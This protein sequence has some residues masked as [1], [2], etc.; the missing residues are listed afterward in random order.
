MKSGGENL[1]PNILASFTQ[2]VTEKKNTSELE[3][4]KRKC[5]GINHAIISAVRPRSF[6]SPPQIGL[7]FTLHRSP[8]VNE[9]T[10]I[11]HVFD[12]ADVNVRTLDGLNTFHAMG[13]YN[14][15]HQLLVLKPK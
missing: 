6:L 3:K 13:E 7:A 15:L 10:F 8:N 12:K 1:I 11:Q 9:E 14:L 2:K 5:V 4:L